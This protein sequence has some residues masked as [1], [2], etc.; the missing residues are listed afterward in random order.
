MTT[1][2]TEADLDFVIGGAFDYRGVS[3]GNVVDGH[4]LMTFKGGSIDIAPDGTLTTTT[5]KGHTT[6]TTTTTPA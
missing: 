1:L 5:T 4:Y 6:T 2:L 3:V